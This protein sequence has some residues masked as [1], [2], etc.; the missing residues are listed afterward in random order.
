MKSLTIKYNKKF[1]QKLYCRIKICEDN[2]LFYTFFN[3]QNYGMHNLIGFIR[4]I[5]YPQIYYPKH[6]NDKNNFLNYC[7]Y[8][9]DYNKKLW[10]KYPDSVKKS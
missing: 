4:E 10:K 8:V 1:A 3:K 5:Y 9:S 7:H 6:R 2:K